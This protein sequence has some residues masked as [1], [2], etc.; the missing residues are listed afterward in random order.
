MIAAV[1]HLALVS[2]RELSR[3]AK[4]LPP[5][6]GRVRAVIELLWGTFKSDLFYSSLELWNAART[7]APLRDALY[8]A[9]RTLG[10]RHRA[11]AA[12]MFGPPIATHPGFGRAVDMMFRLLRGAAVT[13]IL[14]QSPES[15]DAVINDIEFLFMAMCADDH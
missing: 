8:Q 1:Q 11:L 14:R 4:K 5:D 7:D 9:E 10:A 13:R 6:A 2:E 3:A 15:E 12:D